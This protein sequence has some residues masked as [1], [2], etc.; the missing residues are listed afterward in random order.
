MSTD[1][2]E[3]I[4][5]FSLFDTSEECYEYNENACFIAATL[6]GAKRTLSNAMMSPRDAEFH[7]D[8]WNDLLR[9]FGCSGG[10]CAMEAE[11]YDGDDSLFVSKR[12]VIVSSFFDR[13]RPRHRMNVSGPPDIF[14]ALPS[15]FGFQNTA[16]FKFQ[17]MSGFETCN[18]NETPGVRATHR[19]LLF[20]CV[21]IKCDCNLY[22]QSCPATN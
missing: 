5:G 11:A 12:C 4:I 20:F 9:D 14:F 10:E 6:D 16:V 21:R 7:S 3:L 17:G 2:S 19:P 22:P 15:C 18:S 13:S 8:F 1:G